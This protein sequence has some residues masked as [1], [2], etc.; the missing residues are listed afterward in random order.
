MKRTLYL[1]SKYGSQISDDKLTV[2][3]GN[4]ENNVPGIIG[5]GEGNGSS[6]YII[7]KKG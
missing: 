2:A 6:N 4:A 1:G 3:I 5:N 7:D